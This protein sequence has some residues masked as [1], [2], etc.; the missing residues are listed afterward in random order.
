M[1]MSGA[2]GWGGGDRRAFKPSKATK[3]TKQGGFSRAQKAYD[4]PPPVASKGAASQLPPITQNVG[5]QT[6]G[7]AAPRVDFSPARTVKTDA[8]NVL[9]VAMD[10]TG[11][12]GSWRDEIFRRCA[13]MYEEAQGF[14][15]DDLAILFIGFGDAKFGD[16]IEV[17]PFGSGPE[18]DLYLETMKKRTG[19]G[20]DEEESPELAAYF[21]H[22]RVEMPKAKHAYFWVITDEKAAPN[23]SERLA[24]TLL[25]LSDGEVPS[26]KVL[27]Q[28]LLRKMEPFIVLRRTDIGSYDPEAIRKFW[29]DT[30]GEERVV[31]LNDGR[32]VVDAMLGVVAKTTGQLDKF[33]KALLNRQGGTKFGDVNIQTVHASIAL[34]PGAGPSDQAPPVM[35]KPLLPAGDDD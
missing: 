5:N 30:V 22:R 34:V 13:L 19:G 18:L 20:G 3:P 11:S 1:K 14:L 12:M 23:V 27:F 7:V 25:G 33:T 16:P 21:V 24:R 28:M 9:M 8:A 17:A 31:P 32:R 35:S 4:S 29:V 10:T 2:F 6:G 15:G 26:T